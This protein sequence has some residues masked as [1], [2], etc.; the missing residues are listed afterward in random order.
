M[1]GGTALLERVHDDIISVDDA[2]PFPIGEPLHEPD[3]IDEVA[4]MVDEMYEEGIHI[5][6]TE[7]DELEVSIQSLS[8]V[9]LPPVALRVG[10]PLVAT[11]GQR[12]IFYEV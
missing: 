11:A 8:Y 6:P 10:M 7:V 4:A 2:E 9:L 5:L 1:E 3:I 12:K